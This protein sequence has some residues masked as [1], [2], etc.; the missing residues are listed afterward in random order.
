M[1]L[2]SPLVNSFIVTVQIFVSWRR[3]SAQ[4]IVQSLFLKHF[5]ISCSSS[6]LLRMIKLMLSLGC[7]L[8][9]LMKYNRISSENLPC[10]L[11]NNVKIPDLTGSLLHINVLLCKGTWCYSK[12]TLITTTISA[13]YHCCP[14]MDVQCEFSSLHQNSTT[15]HL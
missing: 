10:A 12:T 3:Y 5:K 13:A 7:G 6:R 11:V 2:I 9:L 14:T 4:V 8:E 1:K 15:V